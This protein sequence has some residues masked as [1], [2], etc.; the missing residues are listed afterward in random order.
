MARHLFAADMAALLTP[1]VAA[2]K[3]ITGAT[4]A[5]PIVVTSAAHGYSTGDFVM[6]D[7]VVGNTAAIGLFRITVID[8]N[9]Y[10]LNG[11]TGN[12]AYTSGGNSRN[13]TSG[14]LGNLN[15]SA[16]GDVQDALSRMFYVRGTDADRSQ[17]STLSAMF[18]VGL[19]I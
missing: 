6:Q 7:S 4:N 17:E 13:V 8:A 12:G 1:A 5:S 18:P 10:S 19:L 3:T 2:A 11:S 15:P 16:V 14:M 9:T